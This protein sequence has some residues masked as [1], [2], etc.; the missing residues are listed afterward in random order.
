MKKFIAI[1]MSLL[2]VLAFAACADD[3]TDPTD[4]ASNGDVISNGD[5]ASAGDVITDG[6]ADADEITFTVGFDAEFPPFGF[7][8]DDGSY[9]GFDLALAE[10]VCDRL[11][12]TFVAQPIDWASKDAELA[13]GTIDCIWNGFTK[14]GR[15]NDYTWTDAYYDNSIVMV[16]KADSGIA[17]LADLAGKNVITQAASSALDALNSE[18]NADLLASFGELIETADY[19]NAFMELGM[20]TADA[21]AVDYGVALYNLASQEEGTYII[22]DEAVSSEQYAIGF[23]LGN[24]ELAETV[25]EQVEAIADDGTMAMIAAE[26]EEKGLVVDSLVLLNK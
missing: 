12:W 18:D 7:I 19:N 14:N 5:A 9:D 2:M 22:L 13:N 6:N 17:T 1:L 24:T 21:I 4:A 3:T 23:L 16:V 8:A 20:G 25:W 26:Y 15:E 10:E 11:G